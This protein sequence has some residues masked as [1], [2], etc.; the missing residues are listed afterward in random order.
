MIIAILGGS[1]LE[2]LNRPE[3]KGSQ[4]C[5]AGQGTELSYTVKQAQQTISPGSPSQIHLRTD[6]NSCWSS[7]R[8]KM[9]SSCQNQVKSF[10][11]CKFFYRDLSYHV[12][13]FDLFSSCTFPNKFRMISFS[14]Y[15]YNQFLATPATKYIV[16]CLRTSGL[17]PNFIQFNV[18]VTALIAPQ[19]NHPYNGV[20]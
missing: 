1:T 4:G 14:L 6:I 13:N 9:P 2:N 7:K 19:N 5:P 8:Y 17:W 15:S 11:K 16:Q 3:S 20:L 12:E 18:G 10:L